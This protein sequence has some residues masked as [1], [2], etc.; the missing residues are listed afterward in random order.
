MTREIVNNKF[1]Y[2]MILYIFVPSYIFSANRSEVDPQFVLVGEPWSTREFILTLDDWQGQLNQLRYYADQ[3]VADNN[4]A[5]YEALI[6][7]LDR[8]SNIFFNLDLTQLS[9]H[10]LMLRHD[11][12]NALRRERYQ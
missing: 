5:D 1:L 4:M 7:S 6:R 2:C 9:S 3:C 10:Q 12:L 8:S 11:A